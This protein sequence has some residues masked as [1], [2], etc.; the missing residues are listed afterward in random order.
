MALYRYTVAWKDLEE[1]NKKWPPLQYPETNKNA[2][3]VVKCEY[4]EFYLK[5]NILQKLAE[6]IKVEE[7]DTYTKLI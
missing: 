6:S 3:K 5:W 2:Q 7:I 4:N 1:V